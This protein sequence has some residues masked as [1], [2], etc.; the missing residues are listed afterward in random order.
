QACRQMAAWK[1]SGYH[2][3]SVSVNVSAQ[4]FRDAK[5]ADAVAQTVAEHDIDPKMLI[6]ELTESCVM[7]DVEES[8]RQMNRLRETGISIFIDDFGTG[9]SALSYLRNLPVGALKIDRSFIEAIDGSS[10]AT[11]SVVK[12]IVGLAHGLNLKV[13]AEGVET[14][15]QLAAVESAGC[16]WIQ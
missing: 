8:K 1:S 11:V 5:F 4:Q 9:Y 6:L 15:E 14:Q 2:L 10:S 16:D 12:A 7:L 3:P 13:V